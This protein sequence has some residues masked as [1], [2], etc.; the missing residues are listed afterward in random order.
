M[1]ESNITAI[2]SNIDVISS[3]FGFLLWVLLVV[4]FKQKRKQKRFLQLL[5]R[6]RIDNREVL[7]TANK[8]LLNDIADIIEKEL[9][10]KNGNKK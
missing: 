10:F 9:I 6:L 2:I 7:D 1:N 8:F 5:D 4:V 3:A